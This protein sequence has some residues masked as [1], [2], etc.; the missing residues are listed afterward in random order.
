MV[1]LVLIEVRSLF[2]EGFSSVP[3]IRCIQRRWKFAPSSFCNT[4]VVS[5][6]Y[7]MYFCYPGFFRDEIYS[8]FR[9]SNPKIAVSR[10]ISLK[11]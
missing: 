5:C 8:T 4:L 6:I 10:A 1:P 2:W 11:K 3:W 7:G 9:E